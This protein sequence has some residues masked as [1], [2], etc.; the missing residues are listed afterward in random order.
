MKPASFVAA[1]CPCEYF[2]FDLLNEISI[3]SNFNN[4]KADSCMKRARNG[5][6]FCYAKVENLIAALVSSALRVFIFKDT[7]RSE[8][9]SMDFH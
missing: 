4:P 6:A 5:Y 1:G 2:Q 7:S 8:I 3:I 9:H